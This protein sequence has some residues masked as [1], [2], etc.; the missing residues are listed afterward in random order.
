M[1]SITKLNYRFGWRLALLRAGLAASGIV[2][3][4]IALELGLRIVDVRLPTA[5]VLSVYFEHDAVLGW[6]GAPN[7]EAR[8]VTS[9]FDA[10]ISHDAEGWRRT[11]VTSSLDDDADSP[12]QV[13]W[14]VGDSMTWGWGVDDGQ[15]YVDQLNRLAG[16][17]TQY[18]NL[19]VVGYSAVQEYLLLKQ[20]FERGR[21]PDQVVVFFCGNDWE[22]NLLSRA[23]TPR[24]VVRFHEGAWTI[25]ASPIPKSFTWQIRTWLRR[26]AYSFTFLNYHYRRATDRRTKPGQADRNP[27][28][29]AEITVQEREA[30]KFVYGEIRDLCRSH[31]VA[32]C[33]A[34]DFW[35]PPELAEVCRELDVPLL[36]AAAELPPGYDPQAVGPEQSVQFVADPHWTP[37]GHELVAR[38]IRHGLE[39]SSAIARGGGLP[40]R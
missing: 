39:R 15:T 35:R 23:E 32:F 6:R 3:L 12:R 28:A 5:S 14:C 13:V 4:L 22:E 1:R 40:R 25:D 7:A 10:L 24:P 20:Q 21:K 36:C 30:L 8:F 9:S 27:T 26:H 19:G 34:S 37:L 31:Q 38:S 18:R 17:R 33:V 29:T 2:A 11:A 16:P